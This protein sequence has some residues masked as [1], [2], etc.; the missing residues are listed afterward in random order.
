M[1][2]DSGSLLRTH[3]LKHS[4]VMSGKALVMY[5]FELELLFIVTEQT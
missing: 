3:F 4:A 5:D 1:K 2:V